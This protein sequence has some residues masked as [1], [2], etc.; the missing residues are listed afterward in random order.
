MRA[1]L[2]EQHVHEVAFLWPFRAAAATAPEHDRRSL[3]DLDERIEAHLD[4]LR[5]HGDAAAEALEAALAPAEPGLFFALAVLAFESGDAGR[6]EPVLD[7]AA[8]S[9]P[10]RRAAVSA[11][12]WL[13]LDAA[14]GLLSA[15][16]DPA[17][18][19]ERQTLGVAGCSVHRRDP[20]FGLANFLYSPHAPL[21]E[22][23]LRAAG[24]LGRRDLLPQ[25]RAA[26]DDGEEACRFRAA[27]SCALL[28]DREPVS[29]LW[30]HA[31]RG[32][33][34]AEEACC[35]A[36]RLTPW[37][38]AAAHLDAMIAVGGECARAAVAGAGAS[39]D[40]AAVPWLLERMAEPALARRAGESLGRI[41]GLRIAGALAG[42]APAGFSAGPTEDAAD[43][44][45]EMDPDQALPWPAGAAVSA[46]V[47]EKVRAGGLRSGARYFLGRQ[48][49][50]AWLREVL[51]AGTQPERAAAAI[52][53]VLLRPG[54]V[55]AEVRRCGREAWGA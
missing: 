36:A 55:L 35:L 22:R 46:A 4:A 47:R 38:Q 37:A 54:T 41:T 32:G 6:I 15:L 24:E 34:R 30:A 42:G 31:E 10:F 23:A 5:L 49:A 48:V 53:R 50:D 33:E 27:W 25:V 52:E 7:G 29:A 3:A 17:A 11:L 2:L 43:E 19:P 21:R 39:G 40:V 51:D 13:P 12:G 14:G 18:S 20:G 44:R 16:L 45:V 28:G 1:D 26:L 9:R 8:G